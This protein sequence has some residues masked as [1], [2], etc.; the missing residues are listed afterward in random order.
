LTAQTLERHVVASS[1]CKE[2]GGAQ[3]NIIH[4]GHDNEDDN[5]EDDKDD[6]I[7]EVEDE[8]EDVELTL[9]RREMDALEHRMYSE[10]TVASVFARTVTHARLTG[11]PFGAEAIAAMAAIFKGNDNP[12]PSAVAAALEPGAASTRAYLVVMNSDVG[13][14]MLHHLQRMDREIQPRDPI[15]DDIVAFKGNIRP[16]GPTPN[17][18]MFTEDKDTLFKRFHLLSARLSDTHAPNSS[19]GNGNNQFSTF[20]VDPSITTRV[21]GAV[22]QLIP[23]PLEWAPMILDGPNFGTAFCRMF[24]LLDS[25]EED[26][27]TDLLPIL[28]MMGMVCCATDDSDMAHITLSTQWTCL[29]HHTRT[30]EWA[31]EVWARHLDPVEQALLDTEDPLPFPSD[32]LQGLFGQRQKWH[33]GGPARAAS[34][35]DRSPPPHPPIPSAKQARKWVTSAPLW[36]KYWNPKPRLASA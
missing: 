18:V 11:N 32:Q 15:V 25:L 4:N 29:M 7:G 14:S 6:K 17:V 5:K 30:K 20:V 8:E 34:T 26:D 12:N 1:K 23:I 19:R 35:Q 33:A 10:G 36:Q 24:D 22:T 27:R 31:A 2:A 9:L 3:D 13:F 21:T 28:E 16:Q